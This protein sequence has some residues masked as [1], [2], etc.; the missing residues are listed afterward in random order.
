M[1]GVGRN[2]CGRRGCGAVLA[3]RVP[4]WSDEGFRERRP[5]IFRRAR[6][7]RRPSTFLLFRRISILCDLNSA[8]VAEIA[9][10]EGVTLEQAF[11]ITLWRPYL[12]WLEVEF[13]PGLDYDVA[14]LIAAGA[15]LVVPAYAT[16]LRR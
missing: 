2:Q 12:D 8:S 3:R 16:W 7:E 4:H 1:S 14:P 9:N 11:S 6:N 13:V 10:L 15:V 5:S